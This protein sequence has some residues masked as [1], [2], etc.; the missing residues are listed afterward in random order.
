MTS[1]LD[2]LKAMTLVVA[3]TGEGIPEEDLPYVFERFYRG[4]RDAR[5]TSGTGLG[6]LIVV[7]SYMERLNVSVTASR[8]LLPNPDPLLG[9]MRSSFP[10]TDPVRSRPAAAARPCSRKSGASA[11]EAPWGRAMKTA[12]TSGSVVSMKWPVRPSCGWL[13]ASGW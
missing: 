3:D 13:S 8:N 1:K 12:S 2:Q 5:R 4:E 9:G 11:A 10:A 7:T 6:L